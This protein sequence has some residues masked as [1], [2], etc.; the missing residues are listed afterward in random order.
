MPS[1]CGD[2]MLHDPLTVEGEAA[3]GGAWQGPMLQRFQRRRISPVVAL[4]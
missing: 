1:F 3:Q 2:E 4:G